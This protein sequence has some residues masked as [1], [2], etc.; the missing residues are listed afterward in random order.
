[1]GI[2]SY[3]RR[4][5]PKLKTP[6]PPETQ[7]ERKTSHQ[8]GYDADWVRLR[9]DYMASVSGRCE[10][11]MRKGYLKPAAVVD[12]VEPVVDSPDLRLDPENLDALCHWHHNGWKRRLEDYARKIG[13]I[14]MLKM[15]VKNPETRPAQFQ[16]VRFGPMKA[17]FDAER[18]EAIR[19][20][21]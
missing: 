3:R 2:K 11:C 6:P 1:M 4:R 19:A 21:S 7:T 12:H 17:I 14:S 9:D 18:D 5:A 13:A 15:W 16:I 8:R 20:G 10:E